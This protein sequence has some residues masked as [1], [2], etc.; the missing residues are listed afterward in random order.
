MTRILTIFKNDENLC[1]P[2]KM[3]QTSDNS[4][5][6]ILLHLKP[7]K[8]DEHPPDLALTRIGAPGSA[9][10]HVKLITAIPVFL[11]FFSFQFGIPLQ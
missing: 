3:T 10:T 8:L 6:K 7:E 4:K 11:L 2:K 9:I 5:N 1:L